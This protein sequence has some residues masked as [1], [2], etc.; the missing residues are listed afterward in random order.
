[1]A[2]V[3]RADITLT[4]AQVG[5]WDGTFVLTAQALLDD[6][7]SDAAPVRIQMRGRAHSC[8]TGTVA[9]LVGSEI[10]LANGQRMEL[11][12]ATSVAVWA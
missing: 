11:E 10:T 12:D 1:M 3:T 8:I 4:R 2:A 6:L 9:Q 5:E 7:L